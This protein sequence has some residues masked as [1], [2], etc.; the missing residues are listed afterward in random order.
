MPGAWVSR[1]RLQ[2]AEGSADADEADVVVRERA[3]RRDGHHFVGRVVG[4]RPRAR[5]H[6]PA[7]RRSPCSTCLAHPGEKLSRSRAIV[8][9]GD[10]EGVVAPVVAVRVGG[11]APPGTAA[12]RGHG[13]GRQHA[14]RC[15]GAPQSSTTSSTVT[16]ARLAASTASFC[17]PMMPSISTL[18]ARSARCAWMIATSGRSAGTAAS[19]SPVNGQVTRRMFGLTRQVGAEVAAKHREGQ[20]RPRPPRRR[21]PWRRGCA[22]RSPGAAAIRARPRRAGG[23]AS[24]R[25]GCRPRRRRASRAAHADHL[26]VD[27]VRRHA[28]RGSG[29]ACPG[30]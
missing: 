12:D 16:M 25:R 13:P 4:M 19:T 2:A 30:G 29:R 21:S 3:R 18:P 11:R 14:R 23:A 7:K 8:V 17:T 10:V 20:V 1:A 28:D 22:P 24:R 9:P 6:A 15:A 5:S 27:Q 26:V